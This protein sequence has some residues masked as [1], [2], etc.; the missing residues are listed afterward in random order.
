MRRP[1]RIFAAIVLLVAIAFIYGGVQLIAV[2]GS[3]YYV[4]AGLALLTSAILL[5]RGNKL[6]SHIY[7]AL[8]AATLA[9]SLYEVGTD[10]WA[11]A[12]RLGFLSVLGVGC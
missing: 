9:W 10:L 3:F 7:G 4:L 12:P 6:G 5:W 11:L 8:L 1:P 2:G